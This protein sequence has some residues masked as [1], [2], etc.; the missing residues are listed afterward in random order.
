MESNERLHALDAV[1]SFAL[2]LGIVLHATMSFFL[3]IPALDNSP[4][5]ALGV[6]FF[7]IHIFRMS[8]FYVIAGFF[9]H[10]VFHR[11]GLA[12]FAQE[13]ARRIALPMVIGWLILSPI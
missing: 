1:R 11:K 10:L 6:T 12:V 13:R 2:F 3:P 4:S 9:A 7:V 8:L 5:T